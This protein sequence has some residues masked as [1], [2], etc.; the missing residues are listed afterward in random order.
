FLQLHCPLQVRLGHANLKWGFHARDIRVVGIVDLSRN[1]T[2]WCFGPAYQSHQETALI[3]VQVCKRLTSIVAL[4]HED[5]LIVDSSSGYFACPERVPNAGR[6]RENRLETCAV[7]IPCG[8]LHNRKQSIRSSKPSL[9]TVKYPEAL[10]FH[11]V[12][13]HGAL[14][15]CFAVDLHGN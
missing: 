5:G 9:A 4:D 7:Q 1:A 3:E 6:K 15:R 13:H 11:Q 2:D 10:T 8:Q 14:I 12:N